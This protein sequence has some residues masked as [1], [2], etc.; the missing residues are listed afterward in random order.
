MQACARLGFVS[1]IRAAFTPVFAGL[2]LVSMK[3]CSAIPLGNSVSGIVAELL[4]HWC[5]WGGQGASFPNVAAEPEA[6]E[7]SCSNKQRVSP[8]Y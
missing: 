6:S 2:Y 5:V 8:V 4:F 7:L 3:G 1:C